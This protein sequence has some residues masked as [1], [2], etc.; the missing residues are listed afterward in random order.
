MITC[1]SIEQAH[2]SLPSGYMSLGIALV[3]KYCIHPDTQNATSIF[4]VIL[5]GQKWQECKNH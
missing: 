3:S 4:D 1:P 5:W 2:N